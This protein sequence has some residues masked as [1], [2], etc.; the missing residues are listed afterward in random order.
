MDCVVIFLF[1]IFEEDNER[2]VT[3]G[4]EGQP[5]MCARGSQHTSVCMN[6]IHL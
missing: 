1:W 6:P 5:C 3:H 2:R 4:P